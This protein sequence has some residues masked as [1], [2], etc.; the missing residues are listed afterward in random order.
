MLNTVNNSTEGGKLAVFIAIFVM[1]MFKIMSEKRLKRQHFKKRFL[2]KNRLVL[3][4]ENTFEEIFSFKLNLLNVVGGTLS[5]FFM[6]I[7]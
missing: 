1:L 5:V 7:V 3:L 4:N 2:N 6:L